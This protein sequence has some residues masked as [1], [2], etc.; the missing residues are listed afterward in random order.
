[1]KI[2]SV[3]VKNIPKGKSHQAVYYC[4]ICGS[5]SGP[6]RCPRCDSPEIGTRDYIPLKVAAAW[7][8]V[9]H[10]SLSLRLK[11]A[12]IPYKLWGKCHLFKTA[13]IVR[14]FESLPDFDLSVRDPHGRYQSVKSIPRVI[15]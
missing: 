12:G 2:K 1:M 3:S 6:Q 4:L 15:T 9:E 8:G 13:D 14:L 5:A 7:K 10:H 11:A